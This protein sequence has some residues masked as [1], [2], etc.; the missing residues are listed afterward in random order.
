MN[1]QG[2]YILPFGSCKNHTGHSACIVGLLNIF[3]FL[4]L[5][6]S[7]D[8]CVNYCHIILALSCS[9]GIDMSFL[10]IVWADFDNRNQDLEGK[11]VQNLYFAHEWD[12]EFLP[13]RVGNQ[14]SS[15]S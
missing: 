13:L 11:M 6:L 10:N 4:T 5:T 1:C 9:K 8:G 3:F 12:T 14:T 7:S 15:Q 2:L